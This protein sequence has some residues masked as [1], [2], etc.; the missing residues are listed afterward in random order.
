LPFA[1]VIG[2]CWE[3][4]ASAHSRHFEEYEE[5]GISPPSANDPRKAYESIDN[6]RRASI[7]SSFLLGGG[8]KEIFFCNP[9]NY[10]AFLHRDSNPRYCLESSKMQ[11]LKNH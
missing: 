1:S 3:V 11:E 9:L 5:I 6:E 10:L 2:L 7:F 8:K 4:R